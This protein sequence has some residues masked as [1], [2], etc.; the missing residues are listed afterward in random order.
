MPEAQHLAALRR[1]IDRKPQI[2]KGILSNSKMRKH[3]FAGVG[4]DAVKVV[5]AFVDQNTENALKT[6]PKVCGN[7]N[8][9]FHGFLDYIR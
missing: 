3:F 9:F 8:L 6:K 7:F 1:K 4:A 2:F 5:K